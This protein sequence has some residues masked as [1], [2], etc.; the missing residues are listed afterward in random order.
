MIDPGLR[1]DLSSEQPHAL[2]PLLC[3]MNVFSSQKSPLDSQWMDESHL[4]EESRLEKRLNFPPWTGHEFVEK[5]PLTSDLDSDDDLLDDRVL[6]D[7]SERKVSSLVN[8]IQLE[9]KLE[10]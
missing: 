3:S 1:I 7:A 8:F 9:M 4:I 2:S 6:T 5:T 10:Y